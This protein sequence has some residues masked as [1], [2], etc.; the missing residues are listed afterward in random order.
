MGNPLYNSV[1][2]LHEGGNLQLIPMLRRE[3]LT[4]LNYLRDGPPNF[5]G[6]VIDNVGQGSP[7]ILP[8]RI[9]D[10]NVSRGEII[11]NV[12]LKF[13][14]TSLKFVTTMI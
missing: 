8:I 1:N 6:K 9:E 10:L 13:V 7:R 11:D 2:H 14:T 12:G 3:S 4:A 5:R